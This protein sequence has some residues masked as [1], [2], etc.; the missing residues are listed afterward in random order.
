VLATCS[1]FPIGHSIRVVWP[2]GQ[3][4]TTVPFPTDPQTFSFRVP[5]DAKTGAYI[6]RFVDASDSS[7]QAAASIA[8]TATSAGAPPTQPPTPAPPGAPK[9]NVIVFLGGVCT[10]LGSG[11]SPVIGSQVAEGQR[12]DLSDNQQATFYYLQ[13]ALRQRYGYTDGNFLAYS[14]NGGFVDGGGVWRHRPYLPA[15]P[16]QND[17]DQSVEN[18]HSLLDQYSRAHPNTRFILIGHSLGGLVAFQELNYVA[19]T[20]YAKGA[21]SISTIITVD[22]PLAGVTQDTLSASKAL[23]LALP[24]KVDDCAAGAFYDMQ[25]TAT[26]QRLLDMNGSGSDTTQTNEQLVA[27]ARRQGVRV[28]NFGNTQ[29]CLYAPGVCTYPLPL[30]QGDIDTQWIPNSTAEARIVVDSAGCITVFHAITTACASKTHSAALNGEIDPGAV[31]A[32]ATTIGPVNRPQG[33]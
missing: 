13:Q 20:D 9:H 4:L 19:S 18:L 14:Y 24:N 21:I 10:G 22:S 6:I 5:V 16:I 17:L 1:R 25:D 30:A 12:L 23:N 15:D 33:P 31:T 27:A 28:V 3:T 32:I 26:G 2:S 8:V 11:A 7:I 29:D